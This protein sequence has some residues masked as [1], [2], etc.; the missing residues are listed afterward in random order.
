MANQPQR[1]LRLIPIAVILLSACSGRTSTSASKT[2]PVLPTSTPVSGIT[3]TTAAVVADVLSVQASG[4]PGDYTF[5][6]EVASPDENCFQYADWW[7][8]IDEDGILLY[9]RVLTHSH[10]DEQPFSRSGGPVTIEPDRMVWIR[11]HMN[12]G[13]YGGTAMRGS[14]Q[15]G[16]QPEALAA[17]FAADLANHAPLPQDC[18][19]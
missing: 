7:E 14:V 5:N 13:G 19:F 11:A 6:V 17:D 2:T 3:P 8:V 1:I 16:F 9:R 4:E 18:D 15:A 10:V 12:I